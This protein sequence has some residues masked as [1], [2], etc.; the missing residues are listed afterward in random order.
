MQHSNNCRQLHRVLSF[1]HLSV[2][3]N[4]GGLLP[5]SQPANRLR[6]IVSAVENSAGLTDDLEHGS[7]WFI[8]SCGRYGVVAA[9][10]GWQRR[11]ALRGQSIQRPHR[12]WDRRV[13]VDCSCYSVGSVSG[14]LPVNSF[15]R[16]IFFPTNMAASLKPLCCRS[17]STLASAQVECLRKVRQGPRLIFWLG[18]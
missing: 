15:G 17:Q 9:V 2:A 1:E 11:A 14:N 4:G 3:D 12:E 13:S 5:V 16:W 7:S 18:R 8:A 6:D 10:V